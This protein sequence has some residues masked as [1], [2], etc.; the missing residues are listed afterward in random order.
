MNDRNKKQKKLSKTIVLPQLFP[1]KKNNNVR[2]AIYIELISRSERNFL[3]YECK[4]VKVTSG[5][6]N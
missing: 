6:E 5:G 2:K 4:Y 1:K 3:F